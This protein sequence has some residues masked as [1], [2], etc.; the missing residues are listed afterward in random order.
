M[1]RNEDDVGNYGDQHQDNEVEHYNEHTRRKDE[2]DGD[3]GNEHKRIKEGCHS[4]HGNLVES[5]KKSLVTKAMKRTLAT[6][7]SLSKRKK[8][9]MEIDIANIL[10]EK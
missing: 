8:R 7:R 4:D 2:D 1:K 3:L 5:R 9:P 6:V 10:E